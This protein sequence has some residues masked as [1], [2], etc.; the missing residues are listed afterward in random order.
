MQKTFGDT[1]ASIGQIEEAARNAKEELEAMRNA[2]LVVNADDVYKNFEDEF[3]GSATQSYGL[4][5]LG[6]YGKELRY[7]AAVLSGNDYRAYIDEVIRYLDSANIGEL[8]HALDLTEILFFYGDM[9]ESD[10]NEIKSKLEAQANILVDK[11]QSY[12]YN[13]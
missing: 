6:D 7:A 1:A 3:G 2:E 12:V 11:V 13:T 4:L 10:Y 8:R 5:G 9:T